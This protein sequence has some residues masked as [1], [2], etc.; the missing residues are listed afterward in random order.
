MSFA[1]KHN[2]IPNIDLV[3]EIVNKDLRNR[4]IETFFNDFMQKNRT[5]SIRLL[6]NISDSRLQEKIA[7]NYPLTHN[8]MD[9]ELLDFY[10]K[11]TIKK[12]LIPL[13]IDELNNIQKNIN[14]QNRSNAIYKAHREVQKEDNSALELD[15]LTVSRLYFLI[16]HEEEER[17]FN[18][19]LNEFSK[20]VK[21]EG[22]NYSELIFK[23]IRES[24]IQNEALLELEK[25]I[26]KKGVKNRLRKL[27]EDRASQQSVNEILEI[28]LNS[29][30]KR[31]REKEKY[32]TQLFKEKHDIQTIY[33][34]I[35]Q[36]ATKD[37]RLA[38]RL[39]NRVKDETQREKTQ[40]EMFL[41][42]QENLEQVM[43]AYKR[44][45]DF[46]TKERLSKIAL[47]HHLPTFTNSFF[48]KSLSALDS[49]N[50]INTL[51][52]LSTIAPREVLKYYGEIKDN[53]ADRV[54]EVIKKIKELKSEREEAENLEDEELFDNVEIEAQKLKDEILEDRELLE[55]FITRV[56]ITEFKFKRGVLLDLV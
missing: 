35:P 6:S 3:E 7:N 4:I 46:H 19:L 20:R 48:H 43:Y 10:S 39:L 54:E 14:T 16:I 41:N 28:V 37:F 15:K 27:K 49:Q 36:I 33:A 31:D 53:I 44:I 18:R 55:A 42:L 34:I 24:K 56:R 22:E 11:N 32:F 50:I 23:T 2:I 8:S 9:I 30:K 45:K 21:K 26:D 38:K 40:E 5:L 17:N 52:E 1:L 47:A 51:D 13:K 25:Y 12:K 29:R